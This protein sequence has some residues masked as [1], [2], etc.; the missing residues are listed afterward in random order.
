M[1]IFILYTSSPPIALPAPILPIRLCVKPFTSNL[2]CA[3]ICGC[4]VFCWAVVS[5]PEVILFQETLCFSSQKLSIAK[6]SSPSGGSV[7]TT[8]PMLGFAMD[9]ACTAFAHAVHLKCFCVAAL[10]FTEDSFC[11]VIHQPICNDSYN[12]SLPSLQWPLSLESVCVVNMFVLGLRFLQSPFPFLPPW[13][14]VSH[15]VNT[16]YRK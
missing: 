3:S 11:V 12:L 8:L 4:V 10:P 13:P 14:G 1:I 5:L 9:W 7:C 2:C 15:H 16:I 6:S